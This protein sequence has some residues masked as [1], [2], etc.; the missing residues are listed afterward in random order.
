MNQIHVEEEGMTCIFMRL[1][2]HSSMILNIVHVI[3]MHFIMKFL[4]LSNHIVQKQISFNFMH[5]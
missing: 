1:I 5:I 2:H 4:Y 3:I